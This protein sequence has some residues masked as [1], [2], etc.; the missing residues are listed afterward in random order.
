[1]STRIP[2]AVVPFRAEPDNLGHPAGVPDRV[3]ELPLARHHARHAGTEATPH[4][5]PLTPVNDLRD[6]M[7]IDF[8]EVNKQHYAP[9]PCSHSVS[10]CPPTTAKARPHCRRVPDY[11]KARCGNPR[12]YDV[13]GL[14]RPT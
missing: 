10:P 5:M 4:L 9:T 13:S 14:P 12:F 3:G 11:V 1:M 6:A 8:D 2:N 7:D